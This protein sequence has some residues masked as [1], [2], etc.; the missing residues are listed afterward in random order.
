MALLFISDLHLAENRPDVTEGFFRFMSNHAPQAE[1]LYVLGDLFEVWLGDDDQSDFNQSIIA[2]FAEFKGELYFMHGN[3]DFLLGRRF[4]Q[5]AG[6]KLLLDPIIIDCYGHSTLLMHGDSLCTDDTDYMAIRSSLR[7]P[8]FQKS[9]LAKPLSERASIALN[10]RSESMKHTGQTASDIMDVNP[11]EVLHVMQNHH[12]DLLI[13]GH[14]HRPG[15]HQISNPHQGTTDLT[16]IVLGDWGK[17]GWV[18]EVT[19]T[20][21]SLKSFPLNT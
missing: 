20:E 21:H 1:S 9:L 13:H 3:R 4:C 16:R 8:E 15:V 7:N 14:T 18:L 5:A 17:N 12:V 19:P 2:S 11:D 10:A 6:G